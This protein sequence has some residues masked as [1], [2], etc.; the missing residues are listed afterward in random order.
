MGKRFRAWPAFAIVGLAIAFVL[1]PVRG[2]QIH[3]HGFS[4]RQTAFVRGDTNLRVDEQEHDLST[5][6]FKSQPTS[7]HFKLVSDAGT[8]DAAYIHYFYETPP[9]PITDMLTA[10]VWVK[11][12][13][14]GVQLRARVVFPKEPDP[15]RPDDPLTTVL[16]GDTYEDAK[17]W[18]KLTLTNVPEL[19]AKHLP[20]LRTKAGRDEIGRAHV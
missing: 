10:G 8:G 1:V 4:N 12:T 3:R 2:Q 13:K 16:V 7:E 14:T 11:A 19:L 6:S 17:S 20:V 5:Q 9:A 18:R 15:N